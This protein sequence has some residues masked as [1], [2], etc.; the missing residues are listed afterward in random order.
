LD[1]KDV[2][3]LLDGYVDGELDMVRN[4]EI[5]QHLQTCS[6]CS[7]LYN[8]QQALQI[9]IRSDSFYFKPPPHLRKRI[10]SSLRQESKA[11][12]TPRTT[13]WRILAATLA[14]LLVLS[15]MTWS[16]VRALS[17]PSASDLLAQDVVA[18]H[19][20]SLQANHLVDV[21]SSDQ[22]TVKPWF[23]GKLDFSPPV[24][25]LAQQGY[26]LV[27]GRLDYLDNRPVAALVYRRREHI[28]NLF[29]WPLT[30][31]SDA[32]ATVTIQGY[33]VI[34]WTRAGMN[35]WAVSDLNL[36]E[37]QEFVH[38]IQAGT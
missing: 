18:S 13:Q 31:I 10:Q 29:I 17:V 24:V 35:Y 37:F 32:E 22:H 6:V 12:P 26:P 1:C 9:A 21:T 28:I 7:Y 8:N 19:I 36:S 11:I 27:G 2:Q 15:V 34:S 25:D 14:A 30:H 5:E 16:L 23:N 4:L 3:R 33:H 20:R 38:L